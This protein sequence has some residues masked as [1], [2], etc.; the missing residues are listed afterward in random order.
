MQDVGHPA[1][2]GGDL[3]LADAF[4]VQR[5]CDV[6]ADRQRRIQRIELEDHGD[7]APLRRQLVHPLPRDHD[8]ARRRPLQPRDHAQGRRLAAARRAEQRE[9]A[10]ALDLEGDVVNGHDVIEPLG[11]AVEADVG[12]SRGRLRLRLRLHAALDGH[13]RASASASSFERAPQS[14]SCFQSSR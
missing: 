14:Y 3:R 7:V 9:E 4:A 2:A 6:L 10:P 5:H 11:D 1:D 12:C 8:V 13:Q